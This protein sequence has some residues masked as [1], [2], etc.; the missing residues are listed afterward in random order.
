MVRRAVSQAA[1]RQDAGRQALKPVYT[2][3][4]G[5]AGCGLILA[6]CLIESPTV[7]A[8]RNVSEAAE[9]TTFNPA[10][11][12]YSAMP[13]MDHPASGS[14]STAAAN[15]AAFTPPPSSAI[16]DTPFGVMV[17]RGE[18]IF[19][20]TGR[21]AGQYVGNSLNC[22]SCH[23]DAG[24]L[25]GSAP[26]WAA[27]VR[28]PRY[29]SK[30]HKVDTFGE[31]LQGCFRFSMNG[32]SPPANGK[33]IEALEA[34]SYWLATGAPAD[35]NLP[36]YG[37]PKLASPPQPP[38]YASGKSV[39]EQKCA[40]C[41]GPEGQGQA[42]DGVQ[43]FPPLWGSHSYN[44]GAGMSS[45]KTAAEFVQANMP[46]GLGG[47]L[48]NQEAWD[49]AYFLDAHDR[50]QDPRFN[51]SVASTRKKFHNSPWSLYGAVVNGHLLG[52]P[53]AVRK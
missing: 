30:D 19:T 1:G 5:I 40:V 31:R 51:G 38:T 48:T 14:G 32:K 28:Y 9:H 41:H 6:A 23:L 47:T 8:A 10:A 16:P 15:A 37:Y 20:H 44:W 52:G 13:V 36:G 43:V 2:A 39:Y 7:T 33:V 4:L 46:L 12:P 29:R 26:M 50:P 49:V 18:L 21:Y 24:R 22:S 17:R 45:V 11:M 3:C 34:Y 35:K 27:W 25:A 42:A 53:S